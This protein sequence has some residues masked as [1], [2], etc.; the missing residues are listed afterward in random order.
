MAWIAFIVIAAMLAQHWAIQRSVETSDAWEETLRYYRRTMRWA[1][2]LPFLFV[3]LCWGTLVLDV[4]FSG[5]LGVV[6]HTRDFIRSDGPVTVLLI[7]FFVGLA[8]LF[9]ERALEDSENFFANVKELLHS[10]FAPSSL[11]RQSSMG[12]LSSMA[13]GPQRDA[14]FAW[15]CFSLIVSLVDALISMGTGNSANTTT[16]IGDDIGAYATWSIAGA[17]AAVYVALGYFLWVYMALYLKLIQQH[18]FT[19]RSTRLYLGGLFQSQLPRQSV[20]IGPPHAGK[21]RFC[22][23]AG[24]LDGSREPES[25]QQIDIRIGPAA[26]DDNSYL[27]LTTLD[28]PGENMGDHIL[29]ASVF[30]SDVLVFVLDLG[31]IDQDALNDR[32]NYSL[33]RWH[34]LILDGPDEAIPQT[35]R[36]MQGFHLATT[37]SLDGRVLN[38]ADLFRVRAFT[39]YLNEKEAG[40][41]EQIRDVLDANSD[42]LQELAREIG[43]R[44]GVMDED[45]CCICG[46]AS[47]AAEGF[48]LLAKSTKVRLRSSVWPALHD[49]TESA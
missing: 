10:F 21:T 17:A 20:L 19:G 16:P 33:D 23:E 29:L 25:T 5:K 38:P 7:A 8:R 27:Q 18:H 47:S 26:S 42:N 28:T 34:N 41:I 24:A 14:W 6:Q 31:M 11:A 4:F 15:L 46:N 9:A 44:F 12:R 43:R 36:Y 30:R 49:E 13:I 1:V 22:Q 40:L 45:S 32:R 48:H 3:I 35:K 39:L 37:R 2:A